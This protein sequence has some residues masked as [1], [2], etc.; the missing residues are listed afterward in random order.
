MTVDLDEVLTLLLATGE[1]ADGQTAASIREQISDFTEQ[2][3]KYLSGAQ[4]L[5]AA[6]L[7]RLLAIERPD[8]APA[9]IT[10]ALDRLHGASKVARP[11]MRQ[12]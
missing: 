8:L 4:R 2:K 7:L 6:D 10:L 1:V 12:G 3:A 5:D 11:T 9:A